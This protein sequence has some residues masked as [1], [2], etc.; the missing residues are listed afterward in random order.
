MS[1]TAMRPG[2]GAPGRRGRPGRRMAGAAAVAAR[3]HAAG[4]VTPAANV[5]SHAAASGPRVTITPANGATGADPSA[6]ITVTASGG[7]LTDVTVRTSGDPVPGSLSH[8]GTAWHST[9]ALDVSQSYTVTATASGGGRT[10]T[11]TSAFR[12]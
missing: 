7:R 6:G 2:H 8:G 5:G 3:G 11:A 4:Q 1:T 12:T 10:A 9:W